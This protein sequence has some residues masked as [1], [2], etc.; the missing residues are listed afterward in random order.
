[1]SDFVVTRMGD[2]YIVLTN[3]NRVLNNGNEEQV[4]P[5]QGMSCYPVMRGRIYALDL[6]G[7]LAW[8]APVDV[9]HQQ[10]LLSQPG[11]LPVLL[12]LV[13][14]FDNRPVQVPNVGQPNVGQVATWRTSLVAVDRRDGRIAWENDSRTQ[15]LGMGVEI[16]GDPAEKTV[17][18]TANNETV[19]LAFTGKPV[20]TVVRQSTGVKKPAGKLGQ[21]LLDAVEGATGLQ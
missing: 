4:Q 16:R 19:N 18:I 7:K 3:D 8:P 21:A 20:K 13:F 6:Q 5:P 15:V 17:R 14:H 2:Q 10:F 1:M 11:R 9:D 12:F